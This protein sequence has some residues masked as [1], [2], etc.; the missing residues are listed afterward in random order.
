M[1]SVSTAEEIFKKI[2]E[3]V[4]NQQC[5]DCFASEI[6]YASVSHGTLICINCAFE[7]ADLGTT[8]SFVKS[9]KDSWTVKQ[10]KMMTLGGNSTIQK[11]FESFS[12]PEIA[13]IEYKYST[14]CAK[15][16][17]NMLKIIANGQSCN[18]SV[19]SVEE[20]LSLITNPKDYGN[21]ELLEEDKQNSKSL[22]SFIGSAINKTLGIGK[23]IYGKVKNINSFKAIEGGAYAAANQVGKSIKWGA[24]KGKEKIEKGVEIGKET[25]E[26]TAKQGGNLGKK[27]KFIKSGT[28][29]A[30]GH[31]TE[32]AANAYNNLRF[33]DKAKTIKA[34]TLSMLNTIEQNTIGKLKGKNNDNLEISD[35]GPGTPSEYE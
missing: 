6:E 3:D 29:D 34:E 21:D 23:N 15:Y 26:W 20:G 8:I 13:S 22:G 24:Q 5:F 30:Y 31:I 10:L 27:V 9:L 1:V 17:R 35:E 18:I 11:F 14:V 19:P 2:Q 12:M 4:S 32:T 33:T 16:Y 25:L 28:F 7:H